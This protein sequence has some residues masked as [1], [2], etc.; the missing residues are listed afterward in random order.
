MIVNTGLSHCNRPAAARIA[1]WL[2]VLLETQVV[3]RGAWSV[4][5]TGAKT[6][7]WI[8][9]QDQRSLYPFGPDRKDI[10]I[11]SL[12]SSFLGK[13]VIRKIASLAYK[14]LVFHS[15]VLGYH[16]KF[17]SLDS[18][19]VMC[20]FLVATK[21]RLTRLVRVRFHFRVA[22]IVAETLLYRFIPETSGKTRSNLRE[23]GQNEVKAEF[24]HV[25]VLNEEP[26]STSNHLSSLKAFLQC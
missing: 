17:S 11:N 24:N 14:C 5:M 26:P 2:I 4:A 19:G 8:N 23:V 13:E 10:A 18:A 15:R 6:E 7:R 20:Y 12:I 1:Q 21:S 22:Q 9:S 3:K 16:T 25:G